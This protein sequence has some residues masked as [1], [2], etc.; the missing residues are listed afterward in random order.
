MVEN[1]HF[2]LHFSLGYFEML[3]SHQRPMTERALCHSV[4]CLMLKCYPGGMQWSDPLGLRIDLLTEKRCVQQ[5]PLPQPGARGDW[6]RT[7]H[8]LAA[9]RKPS[10]Q[11]I[12]DLLVMRSTSNQACC[13]NQ[14]GRHL[15]VGRL[16]FTADSH[17]RP[18]S[19][20]FNPFLISIL[21]FTFTNIVFMDL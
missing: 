1:F 15:A 8:S 10:I 5:G 18:F 12:E 3:S 7:Q 4:N 20:T 9:H 14:S 19:F 6:L 16:R 13:F 21:S 2:L 17:P 11:P